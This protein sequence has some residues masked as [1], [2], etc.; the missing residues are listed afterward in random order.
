MKCTDRPFSHCYLQ[1]TQPHCPDLTFSALVVWERL[2][3][4]KITI[5]SWNFLHPLYLG[6]LGCIH[7]STQYNVSE[8]HFVCCDPPRFQWNCSLPKN[9]PPHKNCFHWRYFNRKY[10]HWKQFT[11]YLSTPWKQD[12]TKG[13]WGSMFFFKIWVNRPFN[14]K[15]DASFGRFRWDHCCGLLLACILLGT[16]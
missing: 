12:H 7:S 2:S 9:H 10:F 14:V 8:W 11:V 1:V 3:H 5:V 4:L 15:S 13:E 6:S 16:H